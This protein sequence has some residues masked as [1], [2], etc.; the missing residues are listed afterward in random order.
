MEDAVGRG[1]RGFAGFPA[2]TIIG[3]R[4]LRTMLPAPTTAPRP[5]V[6]P[7]AMKTRVA[8]QTSGSMAILLPIMSKVGRV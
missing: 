3:G 5:T 7:G 1:R 2:E 6:T 4:S 8:S